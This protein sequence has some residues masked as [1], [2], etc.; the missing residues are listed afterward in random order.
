MVKDNYCVHWLYP[1]PNNKGHTL[2]DQ[3]CS[4][5]NIQQARSTAHSGVIKTVK[6]SKCFWVYL[7]LSYLICLD[8][9]SDS[10]NVCSLIC[11]T[12]ISR[13][14]I[15]K[16]RYIISFSISTTSRLFQSFNAV[17]PPNLAKYSATTEHWVRYKY[18][19]NGFYQST[20]LGWFKCMK[21]KLKHKTNVFV[22]LGDFV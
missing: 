10:D 2:V 22:W 4:G 16:G 12:V 8:S 11:L 17:K 13:W 14:T 15:K 1:G 20:R 19:T 5:Q 18:Q 21:G 6:M 9:D 3:S 7:F